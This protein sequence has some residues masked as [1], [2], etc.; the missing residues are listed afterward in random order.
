MSREQ[1]RSVKDLPQGAIYVSFENRE[2]LY[3]GRTN[4]LNSRLHEHSAAYST[5]F[6][7]SFA[8]LLA[9]DVA[10]RNGVDCNKPRKALSECKEFAPYFKAAKERVRG[11]QVK[12]SSITDP[13]T[14]ALFEIYAS[15]E[16]A[17][18][19]NDFNSH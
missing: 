7:A 5:H 9:K 12:Y 10:K 19:F 13:I 3:V 18:P 1:L 14:Q 4:R 15:V 6:G 2:A 11:M 16:L 17:T 8:F